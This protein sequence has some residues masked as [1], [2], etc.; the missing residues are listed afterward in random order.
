[1][2]LLSPYC[3]SVSADSSAGQGYAREMERLAAGDYISLLKDCLAN[4]MIFI[5]TEI[6]E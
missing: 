6:C 5:T 3:T 2:F 4:L 1:M